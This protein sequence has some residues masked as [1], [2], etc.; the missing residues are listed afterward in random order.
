MSIFFKSPLDIEIRLKGEDQREHVDVKTDKGRREK[1]PL[2]LDGETVKGSVT[3]RPRDGKKLEHTGIKVQFIG[4]IG[5]DCMCHMR[6]IGS[7]RS[8]NE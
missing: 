7:N 3:I 2:Y 8:R 4:S 1:F 5:K 6:V